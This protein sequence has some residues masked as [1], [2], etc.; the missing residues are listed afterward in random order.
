LLLEK[1]GAAHRQRTVKRGESKKKRELRKG[2]R[3]GGRLE[4]VTKGEFGI[5]ALYKRSCKKKSEDHRGKVVQKKIQKE[6]RDRK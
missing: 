1:S 4:I 5:K 6:R 2:A 3:T